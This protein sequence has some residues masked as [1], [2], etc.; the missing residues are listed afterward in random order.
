MLCVA[1]TLKGRV[2]VP[3]AAIRRPQIVDDYVNNPW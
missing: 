1:R 2:D 3:L